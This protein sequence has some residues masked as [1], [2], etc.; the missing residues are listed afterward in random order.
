M[1]SDFLDLIFQLQFGNPAAQSNAFS[2]LKRK[3][4]KENILNE[5]Q[6]EGI[7]KIRRMT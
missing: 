7:E 5:L 2:E 4:M 6:K 1:P 3:G